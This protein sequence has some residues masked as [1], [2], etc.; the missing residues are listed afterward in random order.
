[1]KIVSILSG[2]ALLGSL[3]AGAI[4]AHAADFEQVSSRVYLGDLDLS[5]NTGAEKAVSRIHRAARDVCGPDTDLRAFDSRRLYDQ[6]VSQAEGRA[7]TSLDMP[8]VTA[9]SAHNERPIRV[10]AKSH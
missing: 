9:A 7:V 6:C 2:F 3:S 10:A 5:T 1:M 4:P 8:M